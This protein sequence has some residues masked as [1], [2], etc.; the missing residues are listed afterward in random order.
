MF[1]VFSEG[2][3]ESELKLGKSLLVSLTRAVV[4]TCEAM[5]EQASDFGRARWFTGLRFFTFKQ[6][7]APIS[8]QGEGGHFFVYQGL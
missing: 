8:W 3:E 6:H 2:E 4:V 5:L 7:L 1:A